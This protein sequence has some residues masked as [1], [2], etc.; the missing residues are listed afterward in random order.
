MRLTQYFN[1]EGILNSTKIF[2]NKN[3]IRPGL[4]VNSINDLDLNWLIND[5]KIKCIIFDKDNTLTNPNCNKFPSNIQSKLDEFKTVFG[6]EKLAIISNT[7]GSKN[8]LNY[9]VKIE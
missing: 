6:R 8:D 3:L 7:A 5:Q 4:K 2:R 9:E 1:I